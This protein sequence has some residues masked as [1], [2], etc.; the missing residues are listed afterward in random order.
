MRAWLWLVVAACTLTCSQLVPAPMK[1]EVKETY[2]RQYWYAQA[3]ETL[4]KRLQYATSNKPVAK[5]IILVVGDGMSL[6][7]ATA[8]RV[9]RGQRRGGRGE[10]HDLA[11]D[12]FPAVALAKRRGGRGEEHDLAWDTFPAVA[13]AKRRGGAGRSTTSPGTPSPPSRSS[14][15]H[16]HTRFAPKYPHAIIVW[17]TPSHTTNTWHY[18]GIEV[19]Q[20]Y[21]GAA[22][23]QATPPGLA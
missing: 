17:P 2:D 19:S 6:T 3:Q 8:A 4:Q 23:R 9:L 11:W 18:S 14:R 13:L 22:A 21:H 10:E 7:T 20:L 16:T 15:Y 1:A 5:N 12:T